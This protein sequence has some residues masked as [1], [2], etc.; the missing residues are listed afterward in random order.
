MIYCQHCQVQPVP[1]GNRKYCADCSPRASAIWKAAQRREWRERWEAEGRQG[2]P[3]YLDGWPDRAAY[4]AY[5]RRYM[6]RR[7]ERTAR[8]HESAGDADTSLALISQY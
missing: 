2:D 3:P 1:E 8:S 5:H 7:R 4:R 6:Q